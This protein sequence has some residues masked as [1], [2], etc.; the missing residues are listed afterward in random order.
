MNSASVT[1]RSAAPAGAKPTAAG[2]TPT[3][4]FIYA[5]LDPAG[6]DLL[7]SAL[8]ATGVFFADKN[9]PEGVRD[10]YLRRLRES[11]ICFGNVPAEW[12]PT[13]PRLRWL[14]LESIGFEYYRH[15]HGSLPSL[16][17]TNLKGLFDRPAAETAL[18]G[19]L[20]LHRGVDA[21]VP[22]QAA[23]RWVC[24]EVRPRMRLLHGKRVII[25]GHGSIGRKL[26]RLIEAFD[27]RVL[28]YARTANDAEL[29][30]PAELDRALPHAD[31]VAC[32][33]PDTPDTRGFFGG[34]RLASLPPHAV[35]VNIGRG[36]VV[37]ESALVEALLAHRIGGAVLDVTAQ[38]PLPADHALWTC[39]NTLLMQ[40]TGGGYDGELLDKAR[41]FL[42]NFAAFQNGEPLVNV[43]DLARGY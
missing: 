21:L 12:L 38:E 11:E 19:L 43:V 14:Q 23:H 1:R 41:A 37:D 17:I 42:A 18:A 7:S 3:S 5:H 15:L 31:I 30:T 25:L 6:M 40:H 39:P 2:S 27:C 20:A 22:A 29:R 10:G 4:I 26:R 35:F 13:A 28:S 33:L 16:T 8:P 9:G 32:C 36:S 34:T 24:L